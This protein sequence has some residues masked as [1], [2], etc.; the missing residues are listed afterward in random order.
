MIE[1]FSNFK[2]I[3]LFEMN[4]E[5]RLIPEKVMLI[6]HH[7]KIFLLDYWGKLLL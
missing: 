5:T 3:F 7:F 1:L 4:R 6:E 2:S